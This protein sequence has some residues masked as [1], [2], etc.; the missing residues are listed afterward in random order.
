MGESDTLVIMLLFLG[1]RVSPQALLYFW[2]VR[3]S[4]TLSLLFFWGGGV[5]A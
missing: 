5:G 4:D 2:G 1:G 3:G